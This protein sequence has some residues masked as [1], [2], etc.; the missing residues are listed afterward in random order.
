MK[1]NFSIRA[2]VWR[3]P[4]DAGWHFVNVERA[5]SRVIRAKYTKGFVYVNAKVGKTSWETSLF[6]HKI[7]ESYLLCIKK[8]VRAREDIWE[9]DEIKIDFKLK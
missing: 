1:K 5:I 3:W 8:S 7:S 4:G 6:P 2:K 9:G